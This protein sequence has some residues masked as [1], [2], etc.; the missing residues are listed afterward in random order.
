[1]AEKLTVYFACSIRGEQG[2]EDEKR[3]I[4]TAVPQD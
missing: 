3:L 2:G 4:V 1:M